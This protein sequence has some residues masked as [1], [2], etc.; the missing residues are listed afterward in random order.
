MNNLP[1]DFIIKG[2]IF[3]VLKDF[4]IHCFSDRDVE[5]VYE[6]AR[7][8]ALAFSEKRSLC[9]TRYEIYSAVL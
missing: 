7:Q 5:L 9:K 2:I 1:I 6:L 8:D 4:N 3:S